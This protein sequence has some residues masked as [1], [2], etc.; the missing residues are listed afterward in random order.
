MKIRINKKTWILSFIILFL[1]LALILEVQYR[2]GYVGYA[3]EAFSALML[4][5]LLKLALNGKLE[6]QDLTMLIVL[7]LFAVI[8]LISNYVS[9]LFHN[10]LLIALDA[11]WQWKIFVAFLGAKYLSGYDRRGTL[12]SGLAPF[13]KLLI[14]SAFVFGV[15]SF[16]ID[17][18][19]TDGYRY[20]IPA[21]SFIFGNHGRYGI[22]IA[23]ALLIVI[24]GEKNPRKN[25]AYVIMA[26]VDMILSTKGVVYV[27]LPIFYLLWFVFS[28]IEKTGRIKPWIIVLVVLAGISVSSFQ[29]REY[30]LDE[31]APR[32]LLLQY[33]FITANTYF[34][35]GSGFGTYG[36]DI[37]ATYYSPLYVLYGWADKWSMGTQNGAALNDNY[38]ATIIGETGYMG[39]LLYLVALYIVYKQVNAIQ[40]KAQVKALVLSLFVCMVVAFL[41]TGITKSSI[42]VLVFIVLG[43]MIGE[44]RR[45]MEQ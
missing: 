24:V 39:L 26:T 42:G 31:R 7:V 23:A 22:I 14:L 44:S 35:L 17:F 28:K 4:V 29:I 21:F 15:L 10:V 32:A 12:I 37:A 33:G 40:M 43:V 20:G 9:Q 41:A 8:G 36:S 2:V 30:L 6:S 45:R 25:R 5:Y 11:F 34:P 1:P 38:M 18:G 16:W 27:I 19:M 13:A 3:D